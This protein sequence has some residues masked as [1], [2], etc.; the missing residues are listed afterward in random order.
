MSGA[1]CDC[2]GVPYAIFKAHKLSLYHGSN[3]IARKYAEGLER[4]TS[5]NQL[6]VGMAVYKWS[7]SGSEPEKYRADGLGDFH[8]IGIVTSVSPLRVVHQ[9]SA[10]GHTAVDTSIKKW[11]YCS[12]LKG[13]QYAAQPK[14]Q[15]NLNPISNEEGTNMYKVKITAKSLRIRAEAST[16]SAVL[17]N[18]PRGTE[19]ECSEL[20]GGWYKLANSE[21]WICGDYVIQS[22]QED[23][24]PES[25][26]A[27]GEQPEE[28]EP[29]PDW[30]QMIAAVNARVDT[31]TATV[32]G[33]KAV[34]EQLYTQLLEIR[35]ALEN[36]KEDC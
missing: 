1:G 10:E 11:A 30:A 35:E 13:V 17:G 5:V 36:L 25:P 32:D 20:V 28:N 34:I 2:S 24:L 7:P 4:L 33:Q 3:T 22:K 15:T 18:L 8:H 23:N 19:V 26:S 31:L 21:G 14:S 16:G 9:S 6:Q 27:E 12:K 29:V